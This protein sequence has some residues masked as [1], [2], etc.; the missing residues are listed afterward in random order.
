MQDTQRQQL[1]GVA[2]Y[3]L[4][5]SIEIVQVKAQIQETYTFASMTF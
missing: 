2:Q 4:T 3:M 5:C 1:F